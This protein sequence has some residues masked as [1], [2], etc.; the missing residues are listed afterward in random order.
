MFGMPEGLYWLLRK[1]P[2]FN[3]LPPALFAI[4]NSGAAAVRS[5]L[6]SQEMSQRFKY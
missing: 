5:W 6:T 2:D 4:S 1:H 3:N